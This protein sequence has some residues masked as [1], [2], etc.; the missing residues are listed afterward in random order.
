M[1]L[2][3]GITTS[4]SLKKV[5]W[6]TSLAEE[7]KLYRIW[8]GEDIDSLHDI[9]TLTSIFLL[10]TSLTKVGIGITSPLIRNITTIARATAGLMELDSEERFTLGLGI[11][12]LQDLAK[13]GLVAEKPLQI[14][15]DANYLLR[16][17]W[18]GE[19]V[20]YSGRFTLDGYSTRY[21]FKIPIYF[22]A[23]GPKLLELAGMIADGVIISGPRS[24]IEKATGLVK[25]GLERSN[26][27]RRSFN[28]VVWLPTVLIEDSRGM[29]M[30]REV[31]SVIVSDTPKKV[32]EIS[33]IDEQRTQKVRD[34]VS[35]FG[36]KKASELVT[37][38]L[39][40][41]FSIFGNAQ[42]IYEDFHSLEKFGVD[43][44]VFGPPYG[45]DW[46]SSILNVSKAWG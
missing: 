37:G 10:R 34:A 28:I 13:K 12:G 43:E 41:D 30:A 24:Y 8:I 33:G 3:V 26:D 32:L 46:K 35:R 27:P 21:K 44:V 7:T 22:G 42:E 16:K 39:I 15:R 40:K 9:F 11:G 36:V 6:L 29:A 45:L 25:K 18:L 1:N 5:D 17:I 31:V 38:D 19:K 23:R 20:T 2:S 4:A 14:L